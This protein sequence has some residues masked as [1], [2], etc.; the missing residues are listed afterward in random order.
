MSR[1]SATPTPAEA[2]TALERSLIAE[3]RRV[4]AWAKAHGLTRD[5]AEAERERV[6][7]WTR[8]VLR[9]MGR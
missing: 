9:E 4:V 1:K 5:E 3:D 6:R 8:Q 7:G 2:A